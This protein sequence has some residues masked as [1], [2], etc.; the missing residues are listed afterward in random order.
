VYKGYS[1]A[2]IC[3]CAQHPALGD[4]ARILSGGLPDGARCPAGRAIFIN[5]PFEYLG[6]QGGSGT[7]LADPI[8][9]G[10]GDRID[11]RRSR[12]FGVGEVGDP[13][14][15]VFSRDAGVLFS[16]GVVVTEWKFWLWKVWLDR[17]LISKPLL[18][19]ERDARVFPAADRRDSMIPPL[20]M[21]PH[22]R[23]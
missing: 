17:M 9:C 12:A 14:L 7:S 3:A 10:S 22:M 15:P 2:T 4:G 1:W 18:R 8:E 13:F 5:D 16:S 20:T 11:S 6:L 21:S 19:P 23:L